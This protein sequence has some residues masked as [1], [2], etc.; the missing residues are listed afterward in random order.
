MRPMHTGLVWAGHENPA[1][2]VG[3]WLVIRPM[4]PGLV[5]RPMHP[6]LVLRPMHPGLGFGWS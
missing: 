1:P 2:R 5:L 4:H 6:G 3:F